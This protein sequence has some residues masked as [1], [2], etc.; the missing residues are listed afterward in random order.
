LNYDSI[1]IGAGLAGLTSGLRLAEE[2][3]RVL[4]LAKGVGATHLSSGTIDVLGYGP[5]RIDAPGQA[6]PA[7]VAANPDHPYA[8]LSTV[9]I[10][11]SIEWFKSRVEPVR[12]VG[13]LG[14]NFLLSTAI[15][16][17]KPSAVVPETMAQGDLR[18]GGKLT[19]VGFRALK[20]F[21]PAYAADNLVRAAPRGSL[22]ARAVFL[23]PPVG[24]E[25]DVSTVGLARRFEDAG[26]RKAVIGEL[27]PQLEPGE[28]VGFPAVL[29]QSEAKTVWQELQDGIGAPVFEI[30]TLPP[31]VPGIRVFTRFKEALVT[32]G[33]R[34]VVGSTVVGAKAEDG[35]V[36]GVVAEAAPRRVT[37][38]AR[39]VVLAS[40]GFS[41]GGIELDSFGNVRET[42]FGLPVA[43]VPERR[44]DRFAPGYFG[45][46]PM[47]RAGMKV[48]DRLRPVDR[49]GQPA[50]ENL[51]AAGAVLAGA[52]PWRE[53]SGDGIS[54]ATGHRVAEAILEE[55][56]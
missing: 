27:R 13:D 1:V 18:S 29:G 44:Q 33:G 46:H 31:S 52:V 51:Y 36:T 53:K 6:L 10:G 41:S 12:Y 38:G 50:Y 54:L 16:V 23:D 19:L 7:F 35:R 37:Y 24:G 56:R 43:R 4:V 55:W 47:G 48:D 26:F 22:L 30:S 32:A 15:G 34:L 11:Q 9:K 21:H 5:D 8:R 3:Q 42:V 25:R 28:R 20:D 14:G 17:P 2:G 39:W 45:E 49:A 40:G